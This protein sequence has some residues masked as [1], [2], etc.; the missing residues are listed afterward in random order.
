MKQ[1]ITCY[2][3]CPLIKWAGSWTPRPGIVQ[4]PWDAY[5]HFTSLICYNDSNCYCCTLPPHLE[6][7][8]S[9]WSP[10]GSASPYNHSLFYY[11]DVFAKEGIYW[12]SISQEL[13]SG[14]SYL[15][16]NIRLLTS[17]RVFPGNADPHVSSTL[18]PNNI[19]E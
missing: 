5:V 1:P 18:F 19:H 13:P 10:V 6:T 8:Q 15:S 2:I 3:D 14:M 16:L 7:L 4:T 11:I 17:V 9:I 12:H